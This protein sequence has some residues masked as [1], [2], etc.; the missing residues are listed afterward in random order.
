MTDLDAMP[1]NGGQMFLLIV[2]L[3]IQSRLKEDL[4]VS[5]QNYGM[6]SILRHPVEFFRFTEASPTVPRLIQ[7]KNVIFAL[8]PV[9]ASNHSIFLNIKIKPPQDKFLSTEIQYVNLCNNPI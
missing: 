3:G 5:P 7:L 1:L 2:L 4:R 9:S 8:Q 6:V